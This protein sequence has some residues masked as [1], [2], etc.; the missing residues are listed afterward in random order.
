VS[1]RVLNERTSVEQR[2]AP[3]RT[4]L[5]PLG[6]FEQHGPHLPLATDAIIAATLCADVAVARDVDVAPTLAYGASD[7]HRGFSGLLSL[8][9]QATA[10]AVAG[11]VRCAT[12]SWGA[13]VLVCAHGGNVD[14]VQSALSSAPRS[15]VRAWF[16][17]D[18][19]G[20]SHAGVTETSV[21]LSIDPTLVRLDRYP[22]AVEL[23]PDWFERARVDGLRSVTASGVIGAPSRASA[24]Y[25]HDL[26]RRWCGEL[27]A[28]VDEL[29][30]P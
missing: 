1:V 28:V 18:S 29:G 7:E 21:V 13:V 14:A 4:L 16:A 6:S 26:R 24:V 17:R 2:E 23:P 12:E 19:S 3:G 9:T 8:G 25:G 22:G 20:D 5:I 15:R 30:R 11:L 27:V 10:A